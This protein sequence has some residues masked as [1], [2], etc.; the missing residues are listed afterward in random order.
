[1]HCPAV[2]LHPLEGWEAEVTVGLGAF[3]A[4]VDVGVEMFVILR[5]RRKGLAAVCEG[6]KEG[7]GCLML[8]SQ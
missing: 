5:L 2:Y 8:A 4:I 6:R 3:V 1:M 7:K